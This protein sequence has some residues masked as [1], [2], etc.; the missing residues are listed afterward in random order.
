MK[1]W[2]AA[3]LIGLFS[4]N[5]FAAIDGKFVQKDNLFPRVKINTSKGAI[6]V[7]LDRMRA[8]ITVNNFLTYVANG[9]Y[10]GSVFH[11]VERDD[12]N[13]KDF[14]IQ[15]GGYDKDYD[16]MFERAPIFN[17]S[18]NGLRNDMYTIAMA[19]QDNKPHS[20][21]RQFFF[22]MNDNDHLNPGKGWGFAVFGYAVE[23]TDT[24]DA[25]MQVETDYNKKLGYSFI[26]K[27]PVII[28]NMEV[29]EEQQ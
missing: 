17:E 22:N 12:A 7:E 1:A 27:E 25:I 16:G 14:V 4:L 5:S 15:G 28:F 19:Y 24:L 13:E 10:K 20:A 11:R 6:V 8:P 26:P 29:L 21:T 9:D 3:L 2:F 18:G 23:G